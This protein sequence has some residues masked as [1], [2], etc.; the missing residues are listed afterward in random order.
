VHEND[1]V[2]Y[3]KVSTYSKVKRQLCP[4]VFYVGEI[5]GFLVGF[6]AVCECGGVDASQE[7]EDRKYCPHPWCCRL[8]L[9]SRCYPSSSCR[10]H[11]GVWRFADADRDVWG[12]REPCGEVG[13]T[14][15]H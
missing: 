7:A 13:L 11:V 6:E 15:Q 1:N 10:E 3:V 5:A 9:S 14:N 8:M 12:N 4:L 2:E